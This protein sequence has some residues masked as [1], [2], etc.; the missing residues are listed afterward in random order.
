MKTFAA[1][2]KQRGLHQRRRLPQVRR[3]DGKP[4]PVV[5]PRGLDQTRIGG[6][7][8]RY[9]RQRLAGR[10]VGRAGGR[11]GQRRCRC[12]Q[13][14][15]ISRPRQRRLGPAREERCRCRGVG[16]GQCCIQVLR[17]VGERLGV[18]E[19]CLLLGDSRVERCTTRH[20]A[21]D[22][23]RRDDDGDQHDHP[24]RG[25]GETPQPH[26]GRVS[27]QCPRRVRDGHHS[28]TPFIRASS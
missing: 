11:V 12:R 24:G 19:H 9:A 17:G 22:A 23:A 2:G 28:R 3:S 13:R 18:L 8:R 16:G 1:S 5:R 21:D 6:Q 26:A 10:H 7:S 20:A 25:A 4:L 14:L 15:L 27:V